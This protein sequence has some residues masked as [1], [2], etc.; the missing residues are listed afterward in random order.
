MLFR[1]NFGV[2]DNKCIKDTQIGTELQILHEAKGMVC[3]LHNHKVKYGNSETVCILM[4]SESVSY[5][6]G[7]FWTA[8]LLKDKI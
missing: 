7:T 4:R 3:I 1:V 2:L 8:H 6:R 5:H